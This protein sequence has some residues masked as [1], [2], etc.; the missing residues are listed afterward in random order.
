MSHRENTHIGTLIHPCYT[1]LLN[2][3]RIPYISHFQRQVTGFTAS[4]A[5]TFR[6]GLSTHYARS[7]IRAKLK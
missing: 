6:V 7:W 4:G 1:N 5:A 3:K 2:G